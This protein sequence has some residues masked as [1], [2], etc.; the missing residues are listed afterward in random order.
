[1][2]IESKIIHYLS[3]KHNKIGDDCAFLSDTK[4][5]ITTDSLLEGVHFDL[6]YFT[7]RQ[8]AHRI[9]LSNYSDIL[10]SGG[11]PKYALLSVNTPKNK[12]KRVF[13]IIKQL[14]IY[15]MKYQIEL[16]GGDTTSSKNDINFSLTL[17][18]K[19]IEKRSILKRSSAKINDNIYTFENIG[20][21][22]LGYLSI[23]KKLKIS[24]KIK[25]LS[26]K[27][28][29]EPKI[30][31]YHPMLRQIKVNACMD[32][33]DGLLTSL[34][35]LSKAS[36]IKIIINDLT[37]V[38]KLLRKEINNEFIY[39]SLI[40]TSAEEYVPLF[41]SQQDLTSLNNL[42]FFKNMKLKI[43][44]IGEVKK[45]YGITS[46]YIDLKNIKSFDHFK[47][48]YKNL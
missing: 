20:Y 5:L 40:L 11:I 12:H 23:Y 17:L 16:I 48:N 44:K 41:T 43:V 31:S 7:D 45:G 8:I 38:N 18:S 24:S 9:F 2:N 34:E 10:S 33:S 26:Q 32:I 13:N 22:K 19:Q 37:N 25:D 28:F 3:Q 42:K 4:Q 47:N 36:K 14:E 29:L 46:S 1:M 35:I 39:N 21:S 6:K 27:Q 15:L 30:Y